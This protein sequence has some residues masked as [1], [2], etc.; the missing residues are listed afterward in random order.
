MT[1]KP[2][3]LELDGE[4]IEVLPAGKFKVKLKEMNLEMICYKAGRMKQA[5]ISIIAGDTVKIEVSQYDMS[6]GRITYRYN[7][8]RPQADQ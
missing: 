6:Q 8:A 7:P 4:V 1:A 5:H 2:G 3:V